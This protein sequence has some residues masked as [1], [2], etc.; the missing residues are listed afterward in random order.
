MRPEQPDGRRAR[1]RN[2]H[3]ESIHE[4]IIASR[5]DAC[6]CAIFL[7]IQEMKLKIA[8]AV[9]SFLVVLAAARGQAQ[10]PSGTYAPADIAYG[11]RIYTAQCSTCH[12]PAGDAI[13]SVDLRANRF[14]RVVSDT[15][16]RNTVTAGVPGTAMPPFKFNSS[17]LAGIVAYIR[18]M[19]D[20]DS[21][22]VAVGDAGR[23]RAAFDSNCTSCHRVNGKGARVA[24]EL[25]GIGAVRTAGALQR[26][27]LDPNGAMRLANRSVRAVTRDGK[28]ITG[29]RLNEDT[30]TVLLIDAQEQLV[31]LTK[32]DLREYAVIATSS[33]PSYTETFSASQTADVVAYLLSLKGL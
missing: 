25:S 15:D 11:S 18:T 4:W 8:G 27:L 28:V 22:S 20:F 21:A 29:R 32:A 6:V 31:S 23:G 10:N 7:R 26:A 12:G 5:A 30:Y 33:M 3:E 16:L 1:C 2:G 17:E 14:K 9:V 13:A 19:R 24:S